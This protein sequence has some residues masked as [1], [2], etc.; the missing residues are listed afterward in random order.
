MAKK[1]VATLRTTGGKGLTKVI[2]MERSEK[3]NAYAFK[4]TFVPTDD[5]K[6]FLK[7]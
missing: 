3:T 1:A 6:E 2:Q 7:K 4:E 5:V